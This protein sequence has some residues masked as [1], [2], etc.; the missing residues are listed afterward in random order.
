MTGNGFA[1]YDP[2]AKGHR[3][4]ITS[5]QL[6]VRGAQVPDVPGILAVNASTGRDSGGSLAMEESI[7]EV[8]LMVV[9]AWIQGQVVGWVKT[10][11]WSFSDGLALEGYYLGGVTV[12]PEWRR[13]GIGSALTQARLDWIW[14]RSTAAWCVV[15]AA[16]LASIDFHARWGFQEVDR[17]ARFHNTKFAGGVGLL[18]QATRPLSW[19]DS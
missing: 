19:T 10:H 4:S 16:N 18:M 2:E 14:T 1:A 15:N 12:M 17:S 6:V 5:G 11:F 3:D 9:V 8:T 7:A 13:R